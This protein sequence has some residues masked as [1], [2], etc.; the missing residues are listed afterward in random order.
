MPEAELR[1]KQ[2]SSEEAKPPDRTNE[3]EPS[4]EPSNAGSNLVDKE[5]P[6]IKDIEQAPLEVEKAVVIEEIMEP[7]NEE[8]EKESDDKG[9]QSESWNDESEDSKHEDNEQSE[10]WNDEESSDQN[11]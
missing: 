5:F 2:S 8:C 6:S 10:S 3:E 7:S 1:L 9:N 11:K 4:Q